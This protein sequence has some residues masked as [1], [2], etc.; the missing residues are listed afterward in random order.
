MSKFLARLG[1]AGKKKDAHSPSGSPSGVRSA[2]PSSPASDRRKSRQL[3]GFGLSS[4]GSVAEGSSP[5]RIDS[6]TRS[7]A[8][9]IELDFGEGTAELSTH[10]SAL[11]AT[12]VGLQSPITA[13][14]SALSTDAELRNATGQQRCVISGAEVELLRETK[15][16]WAQVE[17]A[18]DVAGQELK[19][20]G[21]H[22]YPPKDIVAQVLSLR[23]E[24]T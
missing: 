16:T 13:D 18:W 22:T 1:G 14:F 17:R 9:K 11:Q 6:T 7:A 5:V 24:D 8:P 4:P 23:L 20:I 21:K 10:E 19:V 2:T 15:F 3:L 12:G